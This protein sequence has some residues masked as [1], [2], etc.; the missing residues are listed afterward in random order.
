MLGPGSIL[1]G[2]EYAVVDDQDP[3]PLPAW[4]ADLLDPPR[5][6]PGASPRA[7]DRSRGDRVAARLDGLIATVL[8]AKPNTRNNTLFWAACR[9]AE[10]VAAGQ[11]GEDQV[12]DSLGQAAAYVGLDHGEAWRTIASALRQSLRRS[13]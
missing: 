1:N 3:A 6:E 7:D 13:A 8:D 12:H 4:M 11:L 10:M 5:R 2:R 9:A